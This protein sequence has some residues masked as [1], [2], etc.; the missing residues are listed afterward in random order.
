M[1]VTKKP[2]V[3]Q[4]IDQAKADTALPQKRKSAQQ[5]RRETAV[6]QP[7]KVKMTFYM[8]G[9]TYLKWQSYK[10]EQL[11]QSGKKVSFQGLI[12][13]YLNRLLK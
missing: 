4:F 3:D 11:Q 1:A 7:K 13:K 12:E 9:E 10:L 6:P 2:K 5:Q 8:P